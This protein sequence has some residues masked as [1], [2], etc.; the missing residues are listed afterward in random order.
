MVNS[1]D[2]STLE[3]YPRALYE[4]VV[5]AYPV[6]LKSRITTI[7]HGAVE[8]ETIDS[9]VTACFDSAISS[10]TTL[11]A[12]DVDTQRSNPLQVLRLSTVAANELLKN[13]AV[14]T[15]TRDEFEV[16]AMPHDEYAIGPLTWLDLGESVH[17]AGITWGAWKAATVLTRRRAEGKIS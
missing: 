3:E 11:L 16:S 12:T 8:P 4:A 13:A 1:P 10:L 14:Q 17:D 7:S 15:P 6:W 2:I 5:S 9:V